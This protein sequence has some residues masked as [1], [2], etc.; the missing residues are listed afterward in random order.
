[1]Y[2]AGWLP[3]RHLSFELPIS[4][5]DLQVGMKKSFLLKTKGVGQSKRSEKTNTDNISAIYCSG[6]LRKVVKIG[7]TQC[8][9]K[10][11]AKCL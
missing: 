1:M 5:F 10:K 9:Q 4:G 7:P 8:D 2:Y 6:R 11:I 3:L